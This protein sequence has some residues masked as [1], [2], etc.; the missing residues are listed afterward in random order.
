MQY[1]NKKCNFEANINSLKLYHKYSFFGILLLAFFSCSTTRNIPDGQYLLNSISLETDSNVVSGANLLEF[2]Q[3]RPNPKLGLMI[4]NWVDN[5][6]TWFKRMIRRIGN[7]PVIFNQRSLT[8]SLNEMTVEMKNRGFLNTQ[9]HADLDTTGKKISVI[10]RIHEGIPYRIRNHEIR[11]PNEDM[12]NLATG[13]RI[14]RNRSDTTRFPREQDRR[15]RPGRNRNYNTMLKPGTIFDMSVL[16][17]ERARVSS[18][19]RNNG[20]YLSTIDN[21][22]YLADTSLRSNEVDLTLILRDTTQTEVFNINKIKVFSGYNFIYDGNYTIVDSITKNGITIYYNSLKFLRPS[23]ITN[24]ILIRPG[25]LFRERAVQSTFDLFQSL[26][27]MARVDVRFKEGNYPDSTLLDSEIYLAPGNMHSIQASLNGTNKAGDLG[28]SADINYGSQNLFNG[29]ELFNIHLNAAYEFVNGQDNDAIDHNFYELG[30]TPSLTFYD[31]HLPFIKD[32]IRDRFNSQTQYSLGFNIQNRPQFTRNFF[33]LN[34]QFRWSVRN[35]IVTHT[36]NLININY[37][38]MPWKSDSFQDY[39]NNYVDS[40]T[41]YSYTNIFTA[42]SGYNL[43]YS[44]ANS[45]QIRQ[46]L[47]T[48]RFNAESSGN[49][50]SGIMSLTNASKNESGQYEILRN[51][52]AQYLKGDIDYSQTIRLSKAEAI[53]YHAGLG[54][55]YPYGNSSILPFEKRY[56]A[57]GP[58]HVRGWWTRYLGP[59]A[60]SRG[61]TNSMVHHVGDINFLL[62]AEY[63]YKILDWLEP[64][65]FV[66]CGNIWTIKDYPDQ[67]G[68]LFKWNSFYKELAVGT[69]IGLRF[70]FT[71]LILRLDMGTRVYDPANPEGNR[72]VFLKENFWNNSAMYVAIGYPF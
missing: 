25:G 69:G 28:V 27:S 54:L 41:R 43:I 14:E 57:G 33:N 17:Q 13:V 3:Q 20:Y 1:P 18:R 50:L 21:L 22:H 42:G 30:I 66:D 8:Q 34:W 26:N 10:Y 59:G 46:R 31:I 65:V 35:N 36:V 44:N 67:P 62:S 11:L 68:G 58:N 70:D 2:V 9:I 56:Y 38:A 39:L 51:P 55:A 72:Y 16:E 53:A 29:S 5:D 63:R 15:R 19:L 48:V 6:S 24:K 52:F 49:V 40:L 71:F 45:G 23:V 32:Y 37:V 4:Y 47:Y 12:N 64:A 60:L 61:N 7:P